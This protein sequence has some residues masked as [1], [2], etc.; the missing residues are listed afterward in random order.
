M[1]AEINCGERSEETLEL[2]VVL[3]HIRCELVELGRSADSLQTLISAIV[4]DSPTTLS[5][6]AQVE[7]QAADAL[8]QR[9]ERLA[10]LS[11]LLEAVVP[12]DWTL[13]STRSHGVI[14]AFSFITNPAAPLARRTP[15]EVGDCEL[16]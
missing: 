10:R 9:L 11:E 3:G 14:R 1:D 12:G 4:T 13:R 5:P 2:R 8:S 7:L 15:E 16:F 6:S